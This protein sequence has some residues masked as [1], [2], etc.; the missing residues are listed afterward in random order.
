MNTSISVRSP[1][2]A[3][4]NKNC[5]GYISNNLKTTDLG[6]LGRLCCYP[7]SRRDSFGTVVC[8]TMTQKL[9]PHPPP[10]VK[11]TALDWFGTPCWTGFGCIQVFRSTWKS[12]VQRTT[13]A[14]A[15]GHTLGVRLCVLFYVPGPL[16]LQKLDREHR[17]TKKGRGNTP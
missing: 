13:A 16:Q 14:A 11:P 3:K 12:L 6:L 2:C 4:Y 9:A 5:L 8:L 7:L 17:G 15:D 1:S 10:S